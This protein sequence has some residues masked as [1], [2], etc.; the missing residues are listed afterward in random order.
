M[1]F[2]LPLVHTF[3]SVMLLLIFAVFVGTGGVL[4][5]RSVFTTLSL[6]ERV[7][8]T[9]GRFLIHEFYLL[10]EANVALTRIK[11]VECVAM[12]LLM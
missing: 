7:R 9:A 1:G 12:G 10:S 5:P 6:V 2:W 3:K 8:I 11:V 4:V